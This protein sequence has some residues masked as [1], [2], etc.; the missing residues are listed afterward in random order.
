MGTTSRG[1]V[2]IYCSP[3]T[4]QPQYSFST[5]TFL[6]V[7]YERTSIDTFEKRG[8]DCDWRDIP[9]DMSD[10]DVSKDITRQYRPQLNVVYCTGCFSLSSWLTEAST[11]LDAPLHLTFLPTLPFLRFLGSLPCTIQ[12]S[13]IPKGTT[14]HRCYLILR[15]VRSTSLVPR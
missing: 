4:S 9:K 8:W 6:D 3:Y 15:A 12:E 14:C 11:L 1:R 7:L 10:R 5:S 2:G 13:I